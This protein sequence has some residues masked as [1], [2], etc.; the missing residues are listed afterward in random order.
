MSEYEF[1]YEI[2]FLVSLFRRLGNPALKFD[3]SEN[4]I[5]AKGSV[6]MISIL[7]GFLTLFEINGF[8]I[9]FQLRN[10]MIKV[11]DISKDQ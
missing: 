3:R 5:N 10:E 2:K 8:S 4:I 7:V 6:Y 9:Y 11:D 1:L